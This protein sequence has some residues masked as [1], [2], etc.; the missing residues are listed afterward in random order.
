MSGD[1]DI[2]NLLTAEVV[3]KLIEEKKQY[4][5]DMQEARAR[6]MAVGSMLDSIRTLA[7]HLFHDTQR[8]FDNDKNTPEGEDK[9]LLDVIIEVLAKARRPM[10]PKQIRSAIVAA[11]QGKMIGSE[12]YL[13][14]ALKRGADRERI[15]KIGRT[16]RLPQE[17]A[18]S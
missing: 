8:S 13:Y 11:G 15:V 6:Y 4:R 5:E 10:T 7:P 18:V 14:T 17:S 16:Y 2:S 1:H 9:T 12:N 3:R